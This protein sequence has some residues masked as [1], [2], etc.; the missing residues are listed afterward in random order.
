MTTKPNPLNSPLG[1][2]LSTVNP[3][4]HDRGLYLHPGQTRVSA[5]PVTLTT[6]LGS[7][8]AVTLWDL[9]YRIGGMTHFMLP[10]WD[11]TGVRSARYGDVAMAELIDSIFRL[12]ANKRSL[13]ARVFGGACV[14][15]VFRGTANGQLG[16]RNAEVALQT[17]TE[18]GIS[19]IQR[20][21][22]G[23]SGRKVLF[24]TGTGDVRVNLVGG[25]ER[26]L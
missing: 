17:L 2:P 10:A 5:E 14:L 12:G 11:G 26:G 8:I 9:S 19:V 22:A 20:D 16:N 21:V 23:T 7:C 24:N 6:I 1:N 3:S 18:A 25:A 4:A 15:S 13:Q